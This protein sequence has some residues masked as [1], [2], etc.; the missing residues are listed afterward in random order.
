MAGVRLVDSAAAVADRAD[1]VV[2]LTDWPEYLTL[3]L[4]DLRTR[5]SG[6]L[7]IDGRN[8]FDP[9]KV[10]SVGLVYEGVGRSHLRQRA[11]ARA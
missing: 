2:L 5:M 3:D 4:S 9:T 6:D 11:E 7:L 8:M 1:A 10:A